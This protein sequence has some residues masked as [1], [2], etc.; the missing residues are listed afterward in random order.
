MARYRC[1]A[2]PS[3]KE[4]TSAFYMTIRKKANG[5][6]IATVE[7]GV[8][9]Q[10]KRIRKSKTCT[11]KREAQ[12]VERLMLVESGKG[13]SERITLEEFINVVYWPAKTELRANTKRGYERDIKLRIIPW[14][15]H[16]GISDIGRFEIQRMINNC[17]TKKI[18]SNAKQTLSSILGTAVN[19]EMIR[20]NPA[21]LKY[22]MPKATVRPDNADGAVLGTF[23][24]HKQL[25]DYVREHDLNKS[26]ERILVLGLCFGLRKG[27]I[28]GLDW[29]NVDLVNR[30]ISITQ[31]YVVAEGGAFLAP[32]KTAK[33]VRTIPMTEYAYERI[34][35]W[36]ALDNAGSVVKT[37][38]NERMSPASGQCLVSRYFQPRE[39]PQ[40]RIMSL[41][42]SFATA[43]INA[44]IEVSS[45]SKMLGHCD[46]TTT[47]NSYVR[48][49]LQDLKGDVGIIDS[50]FKA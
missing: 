48:P 17:A 9:Y 40:V 6:W 44:G 13:K 33:S 7:F 16:L 41:R 50:A 46:V 21:S 2:V 37:K 25:L 15:G 43:C 22:Q 38:F 34:S 20:S 8:D 24:E 11:T 42:H 12:N 18:A 45:V 36:N 49:R 35:E 39:L 14:L 47:Y 30:T 31:T 3:T 32:P 28:F 19:E 23:T 4:R 10:G 29:D 26:I 27:E 5:K 1:R